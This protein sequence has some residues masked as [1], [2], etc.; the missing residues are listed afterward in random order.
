MAN[1]VDPGGHR[2]AAKAA[3]ADKARNILEVVAQE[4]LGKR[5]GVPGYKVKIEAWFNTGVFPWIESG[6]I[7]EITALGFGFGGSSLGAL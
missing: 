1:G 7:D 6:P 2:K 3:G 5:D 4:W